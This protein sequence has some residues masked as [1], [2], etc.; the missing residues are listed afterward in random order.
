MYRL[1]TFG[2]L[3]VEQDGAILDRI[4]AHRKALALLAVLSAQGGAGRERLMALLWPESDAGHARGS[5]NQTT[6]WLRRQLGAP[7]LLLGASELRLNPTHVESDVQRFRQALQAG[8]SAVAVSQYTGPFLD[9]FY[10]DR[11]PEFERWTESERME[12]ASRYAEVLEQLA[13]DA[14]RRGEATRAATLWRRL[15]AVDPLNARVALSLMQALETRGDRPAALRH[16]AVHE[17]LLRD[18]LGIGPDASVAALAERLRALGSSMESPAAPVAQVRLRQTEPPQPGS[19]PLSCEAAEPVAVDGVRPGGGLV[20]QSKLEGR[21]DEQVP[22]PPKRAGTDGPTRPDQEWPP[23]LG[24]LPHLP[25][26]DAAHPNPGPTALLPQVDLAQPNRDQPA[27]PPVSDRATRVRLGRP[28]VVGDR[29][30]GPPFRFGRRE[31]RGLGAS[32]RRPAVL[33]GVIAFLVVAGGLIVHL[34][35]TRL[36]RRTAELAVR[37][38]VQ[39]FASGQLSVAILPFVDLSPDGDHGYIGDGIADELINMLARVEGLRVVARA[40]AFSFRGQPVPAREIAERLNVNHIVEGSVRRVGDRIRIDVR[41]V[42]ARADHHQWAETYDREIGD[43][44]TIQR[45]IGRRIAERLQ[46]RLTPADMRVLATAAT[47]SVTAYEYYLQGRLYFNRFV[48]ED[49]ERAIGLFRRAIET[50]PAFGQA[51]AGLAYAL[52][53]KT[54]WYA[55]GAHWVDSSF[56]AAQKAVALGPELAEA[57]AALGYVHFLRRDRGLAAAEYEK[58]LAINSQHTFAINDLA[59]LRASSGDLREALR[60]FKRNAALDPLGFVLTLAWPGE[61]YSLL[62]Y[63]SEARAAFDHASAMHPHSPAALRWWIGADLRAGSMAEAHDRAA[64]LLTMDSSAYAWARAGDV[65]LFG[66]DR[67]TARQ[68]FERA[69][70]LY[71]W[72]VSFGGRPAALLLGFTLLQSG[73]SERGQQLLAEYRDRALSSVASDLYSYD[74]RYGLAVVYAIRDDEAEAVRLLREAFALGFRDYWLLTTDPL[75][76]NVRG[77]P[78][79]RQLAAGLRSQIDHVRTYVE[80]EGGP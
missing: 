2:G 37:G 29:A 51:W 62:G 60:L 43:I 40:S 11:A 56:V 30:A 8:D 36:D 59:G 78:E 31:E 80:R 7:D 26:A 21:A 49:N 68:Y 48:T 6:H 71:P 4:C 1:R 24:A 67:A 42:D 32:R 52:G 38:A 73:E 61:I 63:H 3:A 72:A 64:R 79:F 18:E 74:S 45:E 5:L 15:Q 65:H 66:Q 23:G 13:R 77:T 53:V 17:A 10:L 54:S 12:L 33:A 27:P 28:A 75:L 34:A 76:E 39:P 35:Q 70:A 57:R 22:L 9:G 46:A 14:E 50:D 69:Y 25:Q 16:A 20:A 44:F 41:L 55:E 58:A 47:Q 19:S